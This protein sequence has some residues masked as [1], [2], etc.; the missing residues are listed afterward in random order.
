MTIHIDSLPLAEMV[1]G[2]G[3]LY[4]S[5]ADALARAIESGGARPGGRL[6]TQRALADRLGVTVGTVTR[7]YAEAERRG[8]VRGE[9]GRG[10]FIRSDTRFEPPP[11]TRFVLHDFPS[12]DIDLSV[13]TTPPLGATR[14]MAETLQHL[15]R[16]AATDDF[17]RYQAMGGHPAHRRAGAAWLARSGVSVPP[18]LVIVTCGAQNALAVTL[19]T[20]CRPGD[21]ILAEAITYPG[22]RPLA[23]IGALRLSGVAIDD[24]GVVPD[25]LDAACRAHRPRLLYCLPTLHNPTGAVMSEERRRRIVDIARRHDLML[26]EDDIYGLL[27]D[28]TPTP[29]A[30]LAPE[31]TIFLTS[32]SKVM[33]AG[34]R[35]GFLAAPADWID[36]VTVTMRAQCWMAA[37]LMAEVVRRWIENGTADAL[38]DEKRREGMMRQEIGAA[39]LGAYDPTGPRTGYCRWLRLPPGWRSN[40]FAVAARRQGVVVT[41]GAPFAA[42]DTERPAAVRLC[43]GTTDDVETLRTGLRRIEDMLARPAA[44]GALLM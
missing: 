38:V 20:L 42:D 41:E 40:A 21:H 13:N 6:P 15:G 1:Q 14:A 26:V 28:A 16:D 43:L 22:I 34:L 3:P 17:L 31:R 23:E 24:Q 7:A 30:A 36:R 10:T 4:R 25:A 9:V 5:I 37:P 27:H 29:L 44:A 35:I 19:T 32:T 11:D 18:E 8:L 12:R 39:I 33:C 2:E